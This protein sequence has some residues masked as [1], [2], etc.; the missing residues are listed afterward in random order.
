[1]YV[2]TT[3]WTTERQPHGGR[4]CGDTMV[5]HIPSVFAE[6]KLHTQ[7]ETFSHTFSHTHNTKQSSYICLHLFIV[8]V[9]RLLWCVKVMALCTYIVYMSLKRSQTKQQE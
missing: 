4:N 3:V 7:H 6:E 9:G 5:K 8:Y 2:I 1:M